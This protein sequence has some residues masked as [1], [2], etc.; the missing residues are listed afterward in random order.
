MIKDTIHIMR[1]RFLSTQLVSLINLLEEDGH[2]CSV[3]EG[4]SG[5]H[6]ALL[7]PGSKLLCLSSNE[8]DLPS[9]IEFI[10]LELRSSCLKI[11]TILYLKEYSFERLPDLFVPEIDD[12]ILDPLNLN[13]LR[14]RVRR[15]EQQFNT[16]AREME[17][18]VY[19]LQSQAGLQ[20]FVGQSPS[21]V[22]VVKEIP[23]IANCDETVLIQ[24]ATGTGKELYARSIHY[25]S[26]RADKPFIPLNCGSIPQELFENELFGHEAGAYTDARRSQ[27]GVIAEAEGGTLFL[28]EINSLPLA[29]QVKLLRLLEDKQYKVLGSSQYRKANVRFIAASNHDLQSKVSEGLFREDLYY[30]LNIL[31]VRLPSLS[32]RREDI[33]PLALHFL[34][35]VANE[36]KRAVNKFSS[37]AIELLTSYSWP[38]N[39]R[40]LENTVRRAVLLAESPVIR[41]CDFPALSNL[42]KHEPIIG[43]SFKTAKARTVEEFERSYLRQ[44]LSICGGNISKAARVAQKDRRTFFALLKKHK[45]ITSPPNQR[46]HVDSPHR[47]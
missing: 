17:S 41:A 46:N 8:D 33:L 13:S 24:G 15:L 7:D 1:D 40:E 9:L 27:R 28:D 35:I 37:D 4:L 44:I 45:L 14:L 2:R 42:V 11:P 43:E 18:V 47:A 6:D 29:A 19:R 31:S 22:S 10:K 23:R 3:F 36:Y 34:R 12:F 30:R 16:C 25:L 26:A 39:V 21:L 32:E 5:A 38:G 20:Q